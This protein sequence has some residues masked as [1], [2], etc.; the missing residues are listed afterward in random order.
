MNTMHWNILDEERKK[1]LPILKP[2]SFTEGFYLAGGTGL[3]LQIGHRDSVDFDFF[4]NDDFDTGDLI[5]K[6]EN[7]FSDYKINITQ[8]E[9]NTISFTINDSVKFSFFGFKYDIL[10]PLIETEYFNIASLED[11]AVMKFGAILSRSLE[12]DYVDL[13]FILQQIDLKTLI[14]ISVEKYKNIDTSLILKSLV[15]FDDIVR[16]PIVYKESHNVDFEDVKEFLRGVVKR[17]YNI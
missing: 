17:Y 8:N 12:K 11:I 10:K 3:A 16:E 9:K 1:I 2:F 13:Y 6:I 15:Y 4:K 14:D 7:I 5:S